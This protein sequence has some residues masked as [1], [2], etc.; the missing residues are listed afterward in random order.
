MPILSELDGWK[1]LNGLWYGALQLKEMS[2]W[3]A[4]TVKQL[5]KYTMHCYFFLGGG[6]LKHNS[7]LL[8]PMQPSS[9]TTK[10]LH[11]YIDCKKPAQLNVVAVKMFFI[12]SVQCDQMIRLLFQNLAIQNT[13][14]CLIGLEI[15]QSR[16]TNLPNT[17]QI[18]QRLPK[19]F[20][21]LFRQI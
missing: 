8:G 6:Q 3:I 13:K 10:E 9:P 14:N 15:S 4:P 5:W 19:P 1:I 20:K 2:N 12:G 18:L 21:I 11:A 7:F 17:K 16:I